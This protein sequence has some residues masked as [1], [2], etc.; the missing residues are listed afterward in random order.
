MTE[1]QE[2]VAI[3]LLR[4]RG[5]YMAFGYL[6]REL[7]S[8]KKASQHLGLLLVEHGKAYVKEAAK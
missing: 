5:A 1:K 3:R 4:Y 2:A 6:Q 8:S 7:G